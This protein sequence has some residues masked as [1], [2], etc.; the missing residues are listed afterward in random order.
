MSG[1]FGGTEFHGSDAYD[2]HRRGIHRAPGSRIPNLHHRRCQAGLDSR[3][4]SFDGFTG[5]AEALVHLV[6]KVFQRHSAA[7]ARTEDVTC[8]FNAYIQI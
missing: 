6:L 7:Q 5:I 3:I 8:H 1:A 2:T 4:Y